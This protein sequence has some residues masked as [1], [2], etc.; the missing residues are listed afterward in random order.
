M[1]DYEP[2]SG[3]LTSVAS[4]WSKFR[5]IIREPC[6]EFIG[7]AILTGVGLGTNCQASLSS[8]SRVA[9]SPKGEWTTV[10]LGWAAGAALAVWVSGG[11][12]GGHINPAVTLALATFRGFPWKKVPIYIISQLFG[13]IVGAALVYANYFHAISIVEGGS[14]VRSFTTAGLFAVY[15]L[16]YMTNVSA[17]FSEFLGTLLL[18]ISILAMCDKRNMA[19]P[20]GLG[21][22]I[23]FMAF[24]AITVAL[25]MET[26]FGINPARDLGP[27]I[28]TS[29]VGYG[30]AVYNFRRQYWLWCEIF[31][32]ILGAQAGVLL[33]DLLL[34]TG[35][36]SVFSTAPPNIQKSSNGEG[37]VAHV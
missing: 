23:I 15:P 16:D 22:L 5:M 10:G 29:M 32:P 18:M 21:P 19:P 28:L 25:G 3:K 7:V 12:S 24:L 20:D 36:D 1:S 33:Y 2:Y 31:A 37:A 27:R 26:S 30:R 8:N 14:D 13:G 9:S 11:I 6:A 35:E 4:R 34:Y 17:F